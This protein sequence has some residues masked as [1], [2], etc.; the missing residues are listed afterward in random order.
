MSTDDSIFDVF[1]GDTCGVCPGSTCSALTSA[2]DPICFDIE[3]LVP[4]SLGYTAFND[5][6]FDENMNETD[7]CPYY[8]LEW[9]IPG[10]CSKKT[11][12]PEC[13]LFLTL[14]VEFPLLHSQN[15]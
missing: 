11:S 7:S 3:S 15:Y 12:C 1:L 10:G 14:R 2:Y 8:M 6:C 9:F 5:K 4:Q 13:G